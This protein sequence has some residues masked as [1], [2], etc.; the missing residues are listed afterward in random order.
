MQKPNEEVHKVWQIA[1]GPLVF[2]H[3]RRVDFRRTSK[4]LHNNI[5]TISLFFL[6]LFFLF[7]FCALF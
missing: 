3:T 6:S 2:A 1:G 5:Y 4:D 7:P